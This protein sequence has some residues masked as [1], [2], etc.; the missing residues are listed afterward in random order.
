MA[1]FLTW[2]SPPSC[3]QRTRGWTRTGP[4]GSGPAWPARG[5]RSA[6]S[7][8]WQVAG[9]GLGQCTIVLSLYHCTIVLLYCIIIILLY[10]NCTIVLYHC[11]ILVLLYCTIVLSLYHCIVPLYYHCSCTIVPFCFIIC[12]GLYLWFPELQRIWVCCECPLWCPSLPRR[13]PWSWRLHKQVRSLPLCED[14][15]CAEETNRS[16]ET[17]HG[18]LPSSPTRL[19]STST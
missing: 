4:P 7:C 17:V 13:L 8:Y 5:P 16:T 10:Y 6:P 9:G 19:I 15:E 14:R 11:I 12:D 3:S 2:I 18:T 1:I